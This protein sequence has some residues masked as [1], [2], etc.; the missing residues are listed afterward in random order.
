MTSAAGV[1]FYLDGNVLLVRPSYKQHWDLPGG[2]VEPGES[3]KAAAM[4]ELKEELGLVHPIG[5]LLVVDYLPP[6]DKRPEL[7]A[8]I[9][10]GGLLVEDRLEVDGVEVLSCA[11]CD[12]LDRTALTVTA[13]ILRRRIEHAVGAKRLGHIRYLENGRMC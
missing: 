13:P 10:D 5:N 3:P 8:Y 6:T 2:I 4:R 12:R 1:L 7:T 9:F 11:W